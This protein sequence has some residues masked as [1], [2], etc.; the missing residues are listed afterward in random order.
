MKTPKGCL[1]LLETLL[2]GK[3]SINHASKLVNRQLG[4]PNFSPMFIQTHETEVENLIP[5][6]K[7]DKLRAGAGLDTCCGVRTIQNVLLEHD[8]PDIDGNDL[9][10]MLKETSSYDAEPVS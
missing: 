3:W 9:N 1:S 7:L 2:P 10:V 5:Y 6:L 8:V 4:G